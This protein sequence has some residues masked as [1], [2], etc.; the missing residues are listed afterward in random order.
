VLDKGYDEKR[1][2]FTQTFGAPELDAA[3]LR[4]PLVGFIEADDPRMVSTVK[5]I[6]QN[7]MCDGFVQRY[8]TDKT[9][10]G[11]G[12]SEGAF[13]AASFWLVDVYALQ[14]RKD[15]AEALMSRLCALAN[16]VGLL[17]EEYG[18]GQLLGNFP[19]ALSHLALVNSALN[20]SMDHG[21][22]KERG[23]ESAGSADGNSGDG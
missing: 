14:G 6:E 13:L 22:A 5:A 2:S 19:Q 18:D 3:V 21:P 4:L 20:M 11:V 8:E 17:S 15:D 10:D 1:E 23:A 9:D 7:L 12:G 16:D